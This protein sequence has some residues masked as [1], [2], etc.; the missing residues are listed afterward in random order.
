MGSNAQPCRAGLCIS[1]TARP[2]PRTPGLLLAPLPPD[3]GMDVV[4]IDEGRAWLGL[5][6]PRGGRE[7]G[8]D[9][10]RVTGHSPGLAGLERG[11]APAAVSRVLAEPERRPLH[12]RRG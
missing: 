10:G 8:K 11:D 5:F 3:G 12:A 4:I 2:E 7:R 6:G 9:E 1:K